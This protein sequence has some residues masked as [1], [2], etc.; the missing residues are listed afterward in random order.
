M[1]TSFSTPLSNLDIFYL[2]A[3]G[4]YVFVVGSADVL[5]IPFFGRRDG[6][7]TYSKFA[8]GATGWA[9]KFVMSSRLGMTLFYFPACIIGLIM[10]SHSSNDRQR[11]AS[12]LMIVH[13]AKRSIECLLLHRFSGSLPTASVIMISTLYSLVSFANGW[14]PKYSPDL[15]TSSPFLG[16]SLY[17][18]GTMGNLY[19]HY[20]LANLRKPGNKAY[21][22]VPVG[23][24]F[25]YVAAPHYFFELMAWLG[26]AFV[27]MHIISLL[28]FLGMT[29]YLVGRSDAQMKWNKK[30]LVNY[31]E[32]RLRIVPFVF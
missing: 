10:H 2:F 28:T 7:L 20:L 14:Y 16:L 12:L 26:V 24:L 4:W 13:F 3:L 11:L 8:H 9:S 31:P 29:V 15:D 22:K 23:G 1:F 27:S 32:E 19:H 6:L 30:N 5:S 18:I 25:H 17:T 21:Y